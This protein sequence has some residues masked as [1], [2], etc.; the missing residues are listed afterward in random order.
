MVVKKRRRSAA[1]EWG[2]DFCEYKD[3]LGET[4]GCGKQAAKI[5]LW[6]I[7]FLDFSA[8]NLRIMIYYRNKEETKI[9]F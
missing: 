6:A 1:D 3:E 9:G 4:M 2:R 5:F 8:A 7:R